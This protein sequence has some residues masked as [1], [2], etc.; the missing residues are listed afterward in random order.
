MTENA[1]NYNATASTTPD[2]AGTEAE[3]PTFFLKYDDPE[4]A[5]W[6]ANLVHQSDTL[7]L[8]ALYLPQVLERLCRFADD[9]FLHT[10][11]RL[12]VP[13]KAGLEILFTACVMERL[14]AVPY[15]KYRG[16]FLPCAKR[17]SDFDSRDYR[18]ELRPYQQRHSAQEGCHQVWAP[19]TAAQL[20]GE[21]LPDL[22]FIVEDILPVGAT[23]FVGRA[24]DGKSLACWNML[25]AVATDGEVFGRYK[26]TPG[27]V[28][29]LALE[30]GKRRA[31]KRLKD[32][33]RACNMTE[34]PADLH[35]QLWESRR[36]G[37]GLEEDL[38]HWI[39][40]NPGAKLIVIDILEKVRPPRTKG[41]S[42]Y[43]DDYAAV[44]PLQK[45]AQDRGI[46]LVIVH[47]TN[48]AKAEDF[49]NT[50]SG[51][52]SL[53]GGVDTLWSLQRIAGETAAM[54]RITGR[55]V[56]EH[57]E[58]PLQFKDG[59][60]STMFGEGGVVLN[61]AHQAIITALRS[62]DAP[63]TPTE[64]ATTLGANLNTMKVHLLRLVE[65]GLVAKAGEGRYTHLVV[66][67]EMT[68][69]AT[70]G[71]ADE[72]PPRDG[73]LETPAQAEGVTQCNPVS[74]AP[75]M[76]Q[77]RPWNS[78]DVHEEEAPIPQDLPR[79]DTPAPAAEAPAAVAEKAPE[80]Q[81]NTW[82]T[83]V[84]GDVPPPPRDELIFRHATTNGHGSGYVGGTART[85]GDTGASSCLHEAKTTE[86]YEDGSVLVKC[87]WCRRILEVQ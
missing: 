5:D 44:A 15:A 72:G 32:Q 80:A 58:I 23:L 86:T 45:L 31:Q 8:A 79:M 76:D 36:V 83:R 63:M 87:S 68:Q 1:P 43:Q 53:L 65:R 47:H 12:A 6:L 24:K 54:L 40:D 16:H 11:L 28:L 2:A 37:Q 57:A 56:L 67:P 4:C 17:L 19:M 34:P 22:E 42:I 85:L 13:E 26:V 69:G 29:Y 33:M 70:D 38:G 46:A 74:Q 41:G 84:T 78:K 50:P 52:E 73:T 77:E 71:N 60:W 55:E 49:R 21:D 18:Q 9:L 20:Y 51:S 39:D 7:G 59:F 48:K 27:P 14:A 25:F 75:P 64:L 61:P 10:I 30:D 3:I 35:L 81:T 66:T 82:V 62:A